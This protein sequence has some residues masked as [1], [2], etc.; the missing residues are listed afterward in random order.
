MCKYG[1]HRGYGRF[2][3]KKV[4]RASRHAT[5]QVLSKAAKRGNAWV[6]VPE[7]VSVPYTD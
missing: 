7:S 5:K 2:I 1:R 3:I 6:E 4:R